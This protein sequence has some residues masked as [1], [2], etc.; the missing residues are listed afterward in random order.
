MSLISSLLFPGYRRRVLGLLLLHPESHYHVRE[1]AR[2]TNTVPG[3]LHRELSKLA[4]AQVLIREESG[5]Q[6]YYR[7][8]IACPIFEELV[9]ILRKTS[10]LVEVLA[11]ALEP[12]AEKIKVA[13]IFGSVARGTENSSSDI[14]VLIIGKLSFIAAVSA[15]H[16]TQKI[17]RREI[18]PKVY[19]MAEW[20][21]LVDN[22]NS[23]AEE[24]LRKQKLFIIGEEDDLLIVSQYN[25]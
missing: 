25:A 6:V 1:L 12:L 5:N 7:A 2:I 24:I 9:S 3:S 10:G 20:R 13:L 17:V 23:F 11:D 15:L 14:D 8:N 18:N 16:P 19:D 22:R 4:E 21:K